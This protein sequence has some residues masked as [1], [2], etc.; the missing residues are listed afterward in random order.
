MKTIIYSCGKSMTSRELV[1]SIPKDVIVDVWFP[2]LDYDPRMPKGGL[3]RL[4]PL[5]PLTENEQ[6]L[7]SPSL[8]GKTFV[9][10]GETFILFML[11]A[12]RKKQI[13]HLELWCGDVEIGVAA[14]GDMID[15][16][17]GGFFSSGFNLRFH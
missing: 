8:V 5:I 3:P 4:F 7:K 16:W 2:E 10:V 15:Y 11:R 17:D 1:N 14:N 12:I 13:A 9:T 6:L